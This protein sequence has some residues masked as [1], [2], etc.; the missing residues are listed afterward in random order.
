MGIA[1]SGWAN[2]T[3]GLRESQERSAELACVADIPT[4]HSR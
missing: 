2:D 1:A 3:D 4:P